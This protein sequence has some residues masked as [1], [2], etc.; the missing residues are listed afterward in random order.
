LRRGESVRV[1]SQDVY[2]TPT[3]FRLWAL[4]NSVPGR[5]FTRADLVTRVMPSTI[6]LER[7]IDVHVQSLRRKLGPSASL[8]ETVRGEG[9]RF[10]LR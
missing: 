5:T 1:G 7:T 6:V 2:L 9:Y 10:R 8:I 4:L 3:E